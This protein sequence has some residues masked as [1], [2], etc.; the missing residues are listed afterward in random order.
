MSD[1]PE[2]YRKLDR[3][4]NF[5]DNIF[6]LSKQCNPKPTK[7]RTDTKSKA[8]DS[9]VKISTKLTPSQIFVDVGEGCDMTGDG[10]CVNA[11]LKRVKITKAGR[12]CNS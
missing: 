7:V 10:L 12:K 1:S 9:R 6:S 5:H 3:E 2:L 4:I 11:H 8:T